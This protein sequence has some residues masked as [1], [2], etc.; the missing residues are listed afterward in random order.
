MS[1]INHYTARRVAASSG[2]K[3]M[4]LLELSIDI[5][6][7]DE[8]ITK[9]HNTTDLTIRE[10]LAVV[11]KVAEKFAEDYQAD[12]PPAFDDLY[13]FFEQQIQEKKR[14]NEILTKTVENEAEYFEN[15]YRA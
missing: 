6:L 8:K 2:I 5:K 9:G 1:I 3:G 4:P 11:T 7:C 13:K 12:K 15:H 10:R 14:I